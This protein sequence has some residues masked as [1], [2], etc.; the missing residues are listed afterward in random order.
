MFLSLEYVASRTQ[1]DFQSLW[2][3]LY[4]KGERCY[5]LYLTSKT[6]CLCQILVA[7]CGISVASCGSCVVVQGISSCGAQGVEHKAH[8]IFVP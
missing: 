2:F 3:F 4:G 7:A 6:I 8:R 1:T 5:N